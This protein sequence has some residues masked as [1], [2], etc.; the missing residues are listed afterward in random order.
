MK[1]IILLLIFVTGILKSFSVTMN[2]VVIHNFPLLQGTKLCK[3][4]FNANDNKAYFMGSDRKLYRVDM[5]NSVPVV[6]CITDITIGGYINAAD[7]SDLVTDGTSIFFKENSTNR[8]ASYWFDGTNWHCGVLSSSS[9]P[10]ASGGAISLDNYGRLFYN[11][12][13]QKIYQL[14]WTGSWT[15]SVLPTGL[16]SISAGSDLLALRNH[17]F[18]VGT[19]NKIYEYFYNGTWNPGF[20]CPSA[21]LVAANSNLDMDENDKLFY[22]ANDQKVYY[23]SWTPTNGWI[24]T[25]VSNTLVKPTASPKV[26][27]YCGK[28]YYID[29]TLNTVS[30]FFNNAGS[31]MA[32]NIYTDPGQTIQTNYSSSNSS[33]ILITNNSDII[34]NSADGKIHM[35]N[36]T[37]NWKKEIIATGLT[38]YEANASTNTFDL[39]SGDVMGGDLIRYKRPEDYQ[40]YPRNTSNIGT[41][42]CEGNCWGFYN[43]TY[44][45]ERTPMTGLPS[46]FI[47]SAFT[48]DQLGN[49]ISSLN[50]NAELSE[51]KVYYK[52]NGQNRFIQLADKIVCGDAFIAS[53]QSNMSAADKQLDNCAINEN[54]GENSTYGKYSRSYGGPAHSGY[55]VRKWGFSSFNNDISCWDITKHPVGAL[56]LPLQY[57]LQ[58]LYGIPTCV[59]NGA[60]GGTSIN[61]HFFKPT[62]KFYYEFG[63]TTYPTAYLMGHLLRRIYAAGLEN[64]IK[65]FLWY[66]G[67][68]EVDYAY[69]A[70][71]YKTDFKK[72]YDELATWVP[73]L[74]SSSVTKNTKTYLFQIHS[75]PTAY[76]NAWP[77]ANLISEDQRTMASY[78]PYANIT[79]IPTNGAHYPN[80]SNIHFNELGYEEMSS[81]LLKVM[82][83]QLYGASYNVN[84]T[85]L[86]IV[87]AVLNTTYNTV[88]LEFNQN[89][90]VNS[91][92]N[93]NSVLNNI[94]VSNG[95]GKYNPAINQNRFSF[96]VTNTSNLTSVGYLGDLVGCSIPSPGCPTSPQISLPCVQYFETPQLG[97]WCDSY[98][99]NSN[100]DAALS[101]YNFPVSTFCPS[102]RT[103]FQS[104]K[105]VDDEKTVDTRSVIYPNPAENEFHIHSESPLNEITVI[106]INGRVC[107]SKIVSNVTDI[108]IST[109]EL[110]NGVYSVLVKSQKE[111]INRKLTIMH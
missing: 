21:P 59:I 22:A 1:K 92:D 66:Q 41:I 65:G 95:A 32:T 37:I 26:Q 103:A 74:S 60:H 56:I 31:W 9:Q 71:D 12:S 96:N 54:W 58:Q 104:L 85:P 81:R 110:K 86:E 35:L 111:I 17:I 83:M 76:P 61:Q 15:S 40:F 80:C 28:I 93:L 29:N 52:L 47:S 90:F 39:I 10:V 108:E 100:G 97:W 44:K 50:I 79:V 20:P 48:I 45:V 19:D 55:A 23:I 107:I 11:G 72:I 36:P 70:G 27:P 91:P 77:R 82:S 57:K 105:I 67:E 6:V 73:S 33:D 102:C 106:D 14:S 16:Q 30:Y 7:N 34:Y 69:S 53:G 25:L 89:I 46:T 101:F 78:V 99:R 88:T 49:F 18:Y 98:I 3:N 43:I 64:G 75:F 68:A 13:D 109:S 4:N 8:V 2:D 84:N 62:D 24:A 5:T 87:S 63:N 42:P 38:A 51:Y 94:R